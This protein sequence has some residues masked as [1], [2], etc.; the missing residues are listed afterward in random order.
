VWSLVDAA[1]SASVVP[2]PRRLAALDASGTVQ[3]SLKQHIVPTSRV[4]HVE[5][6]T[7][8]LARDATT[9][10]TNGSLALGVVRRAAALLGPSPIDDALD[11]ARLAL[12]QADAE[13]MPRARAGATDLALRATAALMAAGGGRAIGRDEHSQRLAREALFLV[14]QG[15]TPAIRAAQIER[16]VRNPS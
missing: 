12:D 16:L 2:H 4:T 1:P 3:L 10:R 14:V 6:L 7:D 9:L 5:A 15:Q 13:A 8:W 11:A